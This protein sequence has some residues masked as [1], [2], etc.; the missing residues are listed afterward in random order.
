MTD[1]ESV[2]RMVRDLWARN[3]AVT[4]ERLS[5]VRAALDRL[6]AG[7]LD[8]AARDD[9]RSEAHKLLGILGTYG[10]ADASVVAGDAEDFLTRDVDVD[11]AGAADLARRLAECAA[12]LEEP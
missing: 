9:A 1:E 8:Q 2:R 5:T 3:R 4:L 6:A 11:V 7:E 10:F 12:E